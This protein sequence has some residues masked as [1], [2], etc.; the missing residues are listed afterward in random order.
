[1]NSNSC[2]IPEC[3]VDS[4]LIEVLLFAGRDHVNHQ[5]GNGNV[6]NEMK[7]KFG[8]EFCIGVIDEDREPLDYLKEFQTV[9]ESGYLKLLKH[10]TK[11]HYIIQIRPVIEKWIIVL[12]AE[13][14]IEL[15]KFGLPEKW[16]DLAKESKSITSKQDQRFISLFKD[17][18]KRNIMPILQ[19][20]N[21][22]KYL[23][24]NKYNVEIN[25]L[26]NG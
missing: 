26:K 13:N 1:M 6:A 21:W 20:Q 3:Y 23:K 17:M 18:R 9:V 10:D 24:E 11:D 2:V 19:L 15:K 7:G 12:C 16:I 4:C 14:E 8:N 25:Q 22:I 5:K